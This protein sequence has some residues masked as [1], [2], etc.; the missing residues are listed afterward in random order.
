MKQLINTT[1]LRKALRRFLR[2]HIVT[3]RYFIVF[4]KAKF[5]GQIMLSDG[6]INMDVKGD[7]PYLNRDRCFEIIK[8]QNPKIKELIITNFIEVSKD[9]YVTWSS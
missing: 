8:E 7:N 2:I 3:T 4:Y 1:K 6:Q 5:E 9:D